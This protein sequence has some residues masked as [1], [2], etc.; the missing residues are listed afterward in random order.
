MP[1]VE[2]RPT[3]EQLSSSLGNP[4]VDALYIA[5]KRKKLEIT[6]N[7]V[8]EFVK[9]KG[10]K[11]VFGAPQR[12]AGKSIS[13]DNNRW[14]MDLIDVSNVPSG[15]WKFFL[16]CCNVTDR[17][18]Y[19]KPINSKEPKETAKALEFVLNEAARQGRKKPQ[20]I[21]SDNGS[22]FV[23]HDVSR[24]LS[25]KH[26]VQKFKDVGDLNALGLLDRQ[27]GLLKSRLAELNTTNKKSWAV[28][29]PAALEALNNTPKPG[30]LYGA[31]PAEATQDP[32]VAFMLMQDQARAIAHNQKN[33]ANKEARLEQTD[34]FRPQV[35][36]G[37]FKRNFQ[38]TYGDP[39]KVKKIEKGRVISTTGESHPLK[40]IRVVP[41]GAGTGFGSQSYRQIDEGGGYV[42][43]ALERVLAGEESMAMSKAGKELRKEFESDGRDYP[44]TMKKIGGQLIDLIRMAP[45]LFKLVRRPHGDQMWYFVS[46]A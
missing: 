9:N 6:K 22:E 14:Q 36:I 18:M 24:L 15:S 10:E 34:T 1:R 20:I 42:L 21:S 25:K 44:A 2:P 17:Y 40:Q 30:V 41:A 45:D 4:G 13:E 23:N 7:Q 29:L 32:E 39:Q 46:L 12:A 19:A 33:A 26:I 16:A 43:A 31:T 5:A 3:L 8:R 11:Q 38:A 35:T 27:I 28:N 37:K